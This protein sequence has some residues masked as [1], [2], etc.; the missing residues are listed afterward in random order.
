MHIVH[1]SSYCAD[2]SEHLNLICAYLLLR[3]SMWYM[4]CFCSMLSLHLLPML[5]AY[6][7]LFKTSCCLPFAMIP[8]FRLRD[9][10]YPY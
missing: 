6:D 10:L 2:I 5:H 9:M 1:I 4:P 8:R 7:F 3:H